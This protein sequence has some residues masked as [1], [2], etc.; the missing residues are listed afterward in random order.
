MTSALILYGSRARGEAEEGSDVDLILADPGDGIRSPHVSNGVSVHW[1]SQ[2]WLAAEA[3]VGNLFVY[4]IAFEGVP[5]I[6]YNDLLGSLRR[7]FR[8]K[9]TYSEEAAQAATVMALAMRHE[10]S[11]SPLIRRRFFWA[12]RTLAISKSADA[13]SPVF[14]AAALEGILGVPGIADLIRNRSS[15]PRTL[16]LALGLEVLVRCGREN[17]VKLDEQ[18]LRDEMIVSGGLASNFVRFLEEPEIIANRANEPYF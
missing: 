7:A 13:G 3:Q 17:L 16:C 5:L 12:L 10:F 14:G 8:L 6:D 15:A 11:E 4:H 18:Q 9:T 1:Y 2:D